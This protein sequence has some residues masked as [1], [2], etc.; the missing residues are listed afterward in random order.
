MAD[1]FAVG[2][3]HYYGK[4]LPHMQKIYMQIYSGLLARKADFS[5]VIEKH[6][7]AY[8]T[9]QLIVDI[10]D[11][12]MRDNPA[13]YYVNLTNVQ[14]YYSPESKGQVRI[15]YTEYYSPAEH[16]ALERELWRRAE[17]LITSLR[18]HKD[19]S[20]R[21]HRLY[22][23]IIGAVRSDHSTTKEDTRKNV[24]A[25]SIVGP[26]VHHSA[27]CGGYA[28][29]FKLLCDQI[30]IS[31]FV[32]HGP[33][34]TAKGWEKH[35]WNVVWLKGAFYHIDAAYGTASLTGKEFYLR[36]DGKMHQDRTWDESICRAER[37][38]R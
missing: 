33:T 23:Y 35:A 30:G 22:R 29:V 27:V 9:T 1:T 5:F 6:N 15:T 24:E 2:Y 14:V 37:D 36:G 18:K 34:K 38:Y 10:V 32:L 28:S 19:E 17:P 7:G 21:L 16:A 8:P 13:I 20:V 31:C 4:L 3:W 26:L 12:V 11:Y 25:R